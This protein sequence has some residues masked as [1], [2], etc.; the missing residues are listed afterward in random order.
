LVLKPSA[1]NNTTDAIACL[2]LAEYAE[3]LRVNDLLLSSA[4]LCTLVPYELPAHAFLVPYFGPRRSSAL[5]S[6]ESASAS[7]PDDDD[8]ELDETLSAQ[9]R[10]AGN[11]STPLERTETASHGDV[12]GI[13]PLESSLSPSPARSRILLRTMSFTNGSSS[14]TR[15]DSSLHRRGRRGFNAAHTH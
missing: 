6:I 1:K 2:K 9:S 10:A 12:M 7:L 8:D 5:F 13:I 14:I 15:H 4:R 3:G 11:V